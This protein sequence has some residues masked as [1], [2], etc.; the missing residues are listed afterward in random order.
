MATVRHLGLF[1]RCIPKENPIPSEP[2]LNYGSLQSSVAFYWRVKKFSGTATI[3]ATFEVIAD[4]E[5]DLVCG[6]KEEGE[7]IAGFNVENGYMVRVEPFYQEINGS[8]GLV[9]KWRMNFGS[10][11]AGAR[12]GWQVLQTPQTGYEYALVP[13]EIEGCKDPFYF[14]VVTSIFEESEGLVVPEF[15]VEEYWPY[16]PNDGLGPIYDSATGAQLRAFP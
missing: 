12:E 8:E 4:S 14:A 3:T 7:N 6:Y 9:V 13:M 5:K 15:R 1:P 2:L 11:D 16:D 10:F